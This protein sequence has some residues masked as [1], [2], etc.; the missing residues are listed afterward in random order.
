MLLN[1]RKTG[2][3]KTLVFMGAASVL[4]GVTIVVVPLLCLGADQVTKAN[5]SSVVRAFHLDECRGAEA[6]ELW[7][8]LRSL[9]LGGQATRPIVLFCSPHALSKT[10]WRETVVTL[11]ERGCLSLAVV[12]EADKVRTQCICVASSHRNNNS[13][14]IIATRSILHHCHADRCSHTVG[15]CV[16]SSTRSRT[17]SSHLHAAQASVGTCVVLS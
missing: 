7:R 11:V 5:R 2:E 13:I 17:P 9:P 14:S 1:V 12:D 8:A 3:G 16:R 10:V 15:A 6:V 4:K